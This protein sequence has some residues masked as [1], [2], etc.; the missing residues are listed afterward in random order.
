VN[1]VF[2]AAA[3]V[4]LGIAQAGAHN[5]DCDNRTAPLEVKSGCCG[6]EDYLA[7]KPNEVREDGYDQTKDGVVVY[8]YDVWIDGKWRQAKHSNAG[9]EWIIAQPTGAAC[10]GVW[11]RR[12]NRNGGTEMWT[13]H[14][15]NT[16]DYAIYC[17][18]QPA[19]F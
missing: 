5:V 9:G 12:G 2:L 10:W 11:Y 6:T 8:H 1:P 15:G 17:L 14:D 13:G 18:E 4:T 19:V 3:F 7:L 16:D